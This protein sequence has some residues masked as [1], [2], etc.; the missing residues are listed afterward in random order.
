[1]KPCCSILRSR[2]GSTLL[3]AIL[4]LAGFLFLL[5]VLLFVLLLVLT[6][7]TVLGCAQGGSLPISL[8]FLPFFASLTAA[9]GKERYQAGSSDEPDDALHG[10]W[11]VLFKPH[12]DWGTTSDTAS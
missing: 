7:V 6:L 9:G 4:I 5:F 11:R 8:V 1:M 3:L 10:S 2:E 12:S